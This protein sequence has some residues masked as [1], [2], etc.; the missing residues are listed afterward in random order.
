[1]RVKLPSARSVCERDHKACDD[2]KGSKR[3]SAL[4][5]RLLKPRTVVSPIHG[6]GV[7]DLEG[8]LDVSS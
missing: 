7:V 5:L 6:V 3:V 2:E 8:H 4:K 1:M